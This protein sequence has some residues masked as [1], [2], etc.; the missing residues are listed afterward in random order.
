VAAVAQVCDHAIEQEFHV[1]LWI[2]TASAPLG[3]SI[4]M[5]ATTFRIWAAPN[6]TSAPSETSSTEIPT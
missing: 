2:H 4:S 1:V 6:S 5:I 3:D